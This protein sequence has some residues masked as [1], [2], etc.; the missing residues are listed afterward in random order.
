MAGRCTH[1]V[2]TNLGQ[3]LRVG[4]GEVSRLAGHGSRQGLPAQPLFD[5]GQ[6]PR[7]RRHAAQHHAG[8]LYARALSLRA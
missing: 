3:R 2:W 8:C 5:L 1:L 7:H 6:A 4:N